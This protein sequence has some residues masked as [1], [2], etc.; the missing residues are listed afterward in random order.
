MTIDKLPSCVFVLSAPRAG[1]TLLRA[2]LAGHTAL[3]SPPELNLLHRENMGDGMIWALQSGI[4]TAFS[5]AISIS[6]SEANALLMN[7]NA[8]QSPIEEV[9]DLLQSQ[10]APKVLVDKSPVYV[11]NINYLLKAERLFHRPKYIHLIRHPYHAIPSIEKNQIHYINQAYFHPAQPKVC[12]W[13]WSL[14]NFNALRFFED[15]QLHDRSI[16]IQYESL[17]DDPASS[18]KKLCEFLVLP[19]ETKMLDLYDGSR[20]LGDKDNLM[21]GDRTIH[22]YHQ[23][24]NLAKRQMPKLNLEKRT[25]ALAR[26]LGYHL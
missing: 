23:I 14:S 10:C 20:M 25:A 9:Y 19:Y 16:T 3:F 12:E 17:V 26:H 18:L 6:Q 13:I 4:A 22:R 8:M 15:E 5:H 11:T 2:L 24:E 1:S 7:L 21:T